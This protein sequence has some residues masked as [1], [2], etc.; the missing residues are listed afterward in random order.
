MKRF[1]PN[2]RFLPRFL[3]FALLLAGSAWPASAGAQP[4]VEVKGGVVF[5]DS[6]RTVLLEIMKEAGVRGAR[7]TSTHRSVASQVRAMYGYVRRHGAAQAHQLYGSEGDAVIAV[8]AR[9]RSAPRDE[10]LTLM[11]AELERQL[12]SAFANERLMHLN[13]CYFVFDVAMSSVPAALQDAF[14]R[15]AAQNPH[16]HRFLGKDQGEREAFHIEVPRSGD[17]SI[18][19]W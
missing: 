9:H 7:V 15:A 6:A 17:C 11:E 4:V 16:V 2:R 14:S 10:V 12:P 13:P 8:Y 3:P 18:G 5:P 1:T 19:T